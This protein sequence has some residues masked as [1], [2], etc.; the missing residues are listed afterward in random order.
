M[1]PHWFLP[2]G[3]PRPRDIHRVRLALAQDLSSFLVKPSQCDFHK[4]CDRG[5]NQPA[6][7]TNFGDGQTNLL[8]SQVNRYIFQKEDNLSTALEKITKALLNEF[9]R[10]AKNRKKIETVLKGR[11]TPHLFENPE[12]FH[13]DVCLHSYNQNIARDF[14]ET[15]SADSQSIPSGA[16]S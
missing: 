11:L 8:D 14:A 10:S 5:L 1:E 9:P 6:E 12:C 2:T 13:R 3:E 7:N 4:E 16:V 15:Q